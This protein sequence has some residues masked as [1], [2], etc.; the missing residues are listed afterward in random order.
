M[1]LKLEGVDDQGETVLNEHDLCREIKKQ[2]FDYR[3]DLNP[4]FYFNQI[5]P[6]S[7]F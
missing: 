4:L 6:G 5:Q 7:F 3:A 2:L 1:V